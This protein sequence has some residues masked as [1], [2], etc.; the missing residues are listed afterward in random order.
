MRAIQNGGLVR[1]RG[2]N[3]SQCVRIDV[4]LKGPPNGTVEQSCLAVW[5]S[6]W[7]SERG[8]IRLPL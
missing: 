4:Q 6:P 8:Y 5:K 2:A 3:Y 7:G 1:R